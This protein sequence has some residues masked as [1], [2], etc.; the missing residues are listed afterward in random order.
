MKNS[1]KEKYSK[2][3]EAWNEPRKRAG[4][5]LISY[6]IFFFVFILLASIINNIES[7]NNIKTSNTTTT[8][9]LIDKYNDKQK[10][11]LTDKYN[12]SYVINI[13]TNEYKINGTLEN[14]IV[15]GYLE[16]V[17][18]IKKIVIRDNFIYEI[19]NNE[20][21]IYESELNINYLNLDN[22]IN[23]IKQNRAIITD[24]EKIKT[25]TYDIDD[26]S[27]IIVSTDENDIRN[28]KIEDELSKYN[29]SFDN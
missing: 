21:V 17:S 3:K 9:L 29:L 24:S 25:Y 6:F 23:L 12:I 7:R 11:L 28:I 5:K 20:E 2:F 15:N 27:K 4:I 10:K 16:L 14:N 22:I 18:G 8:T 26:I 13:D 1:F 19:I